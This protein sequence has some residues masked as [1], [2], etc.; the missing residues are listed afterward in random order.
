MSSVL[1]ALRRLGD[2]RTPALGL[3]L[4][5]L[6]TATVFG[7][8]PRL[9]DRVSDD[10]LHGVVAGATATNRNIALIEQ[11]GIAPDSNDPLKNVNAEGDRLDARLP[12]GVRAVVGTRQVVVDS[13]RY[14]VQAKTQDPT[15]FRFRIQPGALDRMRITAGSAPTATTEVV[16]LPEKLRS[17][18][19]A[20]ANG[21]K[22]PIPVTVFETAVAADALRQSGLS[23]GDLVF[24]TVDSSD[25]LAARR[26]GFAAARI[27][28]VLE[29]MDPA[30]PFWY[31]DQS[32]NQV[33][34][35]SI[36][37]DT[38]FLDVGAILPDA[39]Y[40]AIAQLGQTSGTAVRY[41]WRRFVDPA[42]LSATRLD[43]TI[44]DLRRLETSFPQTQIVNGAADGVAMRS[45]LLPLLVAH[46]ARW[47]SAQAILTVVAIGPASVAVAAL[48]LVATMTARRRRPALALV[49]GRGAT[50]GQIV[51]AL[52]L[53]GFVIAIPALGI[54]TLAAI[55]VVPAGSNRATILAATIVAAVAVGL[56]LWTALPSAL[57]ATRPARDEVAAPRT[58]SA[59]RLVLDVVV[60]VLAATGAY[61]LRE[62]G[63]RG[64][65]SIGTLAGADPLIA[66]VPALAGLAA[67]LAAI[68]LVPLPLR[69]L[70][71]IAARGRGIVPLLAL[72]R[73]IH[74]GTTAAVLIV[75]LAT[76]SIGAFASTALVHLDRAGLAASWH[77]VGAPFRITAQVG[78]I[79]P[80]LDPTTLPGV[81]AA[82]ALSLSQEPFGPNNLPVKLA[83]VDLPAYERMIA[84]S[85]ADLEPPAEMLSPAPADGIIPV[86]VAPEVVARSDG[87]KLGVV[88]EIVVGGYHY[89]I[90]PVAT[91]ATFPTLPADAIFA[92]ASRQQMKA[93]HPDAP[94]SASSIFLAAPDGDGVAIRD[95]VDRVAIGATVTSRST[96]AQG[97]A[98]SPVTA[99]IIAGIAIAAIVAS[100]YAALAVTAALALAGAARATEVAH[101]RMVGLSRGDALGL[102]IVEHGPT[103]I[104]SFVAGVGLG[105][106]LFALLEP[107]LGL[108]AIV[109]SRV[110]IPLTADP[111]QL[112][113]ILAGV[114][115]VSGV[116][117]G[118]AAWMQRRGAA[119]AALRRGFE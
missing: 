59:R 117:I 99:A 83:S 79:T 84:G 7:L 85:P 98:D 70:S 35:R 39:A 11:Q 75:L 19:P 26:T 14:R 66:A 52:L 37:G 18:V 80:N 16:D 9:F 23:L 112:G 8:A 67:G 115:A 116:G 49:R 114:L 34:I 21:S 76:A 91:R 27:T 51:R 48:A 94:L 58:A 31:E 15:F 36:G 17:L 119:V 28:G 89:Q 96:F 68:R 87:L 88:S 44:V 33:T 95:A 12:P 103:V 77:E 56:L 64:T 73:A 62:R 32:L 29:A 42:L 100:L 93:M 72:R 47:A 69:V 102:A 78:T 20:E 71:R 25:P 40:P 3:G 74:G 63:V 22:Q 24:L 118:L 111:G 13:V 61:L 43:A 60:T 2:D 105:L 38:R 97:F 53:E 101:L 82:A 55:A 109:G 57:A 10:A 46:S 41:T 107:G 54:A 6:V 104:L 4:L 1:I 90:R 30:D 45:G 92:V 5:I 106:G 113:L 65:S 86:L 108:D 110:D 50:L 81:S